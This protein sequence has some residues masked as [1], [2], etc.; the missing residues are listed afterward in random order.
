MNTQV[1]YN[2]YFFALIALCI[3]LFIADIVYGSVHIPLKEIFFSKNELYHNIIYKIRL[4]K[5]ITALLCGAGLSVCGLIMQTLFRNPLAGP[6][7][8]GISS[9]AS[10]GVAVVTL[11][12]SGTLLLTG[13]VGKLSIIVA[14]GIGATL[15]LLL[16]VVL[17]KNISNSVTVLIIGLMVSHLTSAIEGVLQFT[18]NAQNLQVFILWGMGNFSSV[19]MDDMIYFIPIIIISIIIAFTFSKHLNTLLWG[20]SYALS[21]GINIKRAR[22][23]IIIITAIIAG[24]I[25][26]LCGP[27][28]FVGIAV[29]HLAR[30]LFKTSNHRILIPATMLFGIALTILCDILTNLPGTNSL[31]PVNAITSLIGAPIVIWVVWKKNKQ[32]LS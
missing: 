14:A 15:A 29:P 20:E 24:T 8:L 17:S 16:V 5:T 9:G 2:F 25:T 10:L 22:F 31:L 11:T 19:V 28:A 32:L 12:L 7:V 30:N 1:K 26:A 23:F 4:P 13:V 27:I 6:F 3:L 21:M 18:S